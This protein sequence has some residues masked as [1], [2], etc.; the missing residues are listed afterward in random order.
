MKLVFVSAGF[1]QIQPLSAIDKMQKMK[2]MQRGTKPQN[3]GFAE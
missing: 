3:G 1:L 2:V